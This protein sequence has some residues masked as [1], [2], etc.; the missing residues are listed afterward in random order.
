MESLGVR[1]GVGGGGAR[2][3]KCRVQTGRVCEH[4]QVLRSVP[5]VF[6]CLTLTLETVCL[7]E[8]RFSK[9]TSAKKPGFRP[10]K[11]KVSRD[12][13]TAAYLREEFQEKKKKK[14]TLWTSRTIQ[15]VGLLL[16]LTQRPPLTEADLDDAPL[17]MF[18]RV[19]L[20]APHALGPH[21]KSAAPRL[22]TT[23]GGRETDTNT[24]S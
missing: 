7:A 20:N 19:C 18:H 21:P 9:Q 24:L 13:P 16:S 2:A 22:Q 17:W 15:D 14:R 1:P 8:L 4:L 23:G 11:R 10:K 12:P 6:P 5:L 3:W